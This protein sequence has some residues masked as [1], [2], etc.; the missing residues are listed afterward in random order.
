MLDIRQRTGYLFLALTLGQII[1]IS[2]QVQSKTGGRLLESVIFSG[3]SEVQRGTGSAIGGVRHLWGNYVAL[4]GLKAENDTL[5]D[6]VAD[7]QVR[8]QKEHAQAQRTARLQRLLDLRSAVTLPT[9]AAEVIGGDTSPGLHTITINKGRDDGVQSDFAVIAAAGVVGRVLDQPAAHAARVQLIISRNAGAGVMIE[10][11]RAG[12]VIV[13]GG[14]DPPLLMEYVANLADVKAGDMVV[15]T[16]TDGIYPKG[17]PVGRVE[18]VE[19]GAG[20]YQQIRVR[21]VVDFSNIEEVLVVPGVPKSEAPAESP[22]S[23]PAAK[24]P[25]APGGAEGA[26]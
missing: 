2:A 12:G 21:P 7:L 6:Q 25:A 3:F 14:D 5:K 24:P 26:R 11:S 23:M 17:F 8:L 18:S 16:G 15:T 1:L 10:R 22:P 4:R 9:I 20:M 19:R 13:G